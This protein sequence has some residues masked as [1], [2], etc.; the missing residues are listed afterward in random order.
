MQKNVD[1]ILLLGHFVYACRRQ[2]RISSA[3]YSLWK[4]KCGS[5]R[6]QLALVPRSLRSPL[7]LYCPFLQPRCYH[8]L[9]GSPESLDDAK[10]EAFYEL[11][12]SEAHVATGRPSVGPRRLSHTRGNSGL[13]QL[14][15]YFSQLLLLRRR[16]C[17]MRFTSSINSPLTG[18]LANACIP[19]AFDYPWDFGNSAGLRDSTRLLTYKSR[20]ERLWQT[21][22]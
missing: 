19:F 18:C 21:L 15:S 8:K 16:P 13:A 17:A 5:V 22:I 9:A 3:G 4:N 14:V 12:Y 20:N 7:I 1:C 2:K 10:E 6:R 11:Y